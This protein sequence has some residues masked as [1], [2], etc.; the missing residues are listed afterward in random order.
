MIRALLTGTLTRYWRSLLS[1]LLITVFLSLA[2]FSFLSIERLAEG[3]L[4]SATSQELGKTK[5]Q[6]SDDEQLAGELLK[7]IEKQKEFSTFELVTKREAFA[8]STHQASSVVINSFS[9]HTE[10]K[11]P[12]TTGEYPQN[13]DEILISNELAETLNVDIGQSL[14][15]LINHDSSQY[16]IGKVVGVFKKDFLTLEPRALEIYSTN[17]DFILGKNWLSTPLQDTDKINLISSEKAHSAA[18][19]TAAVTKISA[20]TTLSRA[21]VQA[22]IRNTLSEQYRYYIYTARWLVAA[23]TL[24]AIAVL[25]ISFWRYTDLRQ[26]DFIRLR[27]LG[28]SRR[29][30]ITIQALEFFTIVFF[31]ALITNFMIR[32]ILLGIREDSQLLSAL[33]FTIKENYFTW[34]GFLISILIAIIIGILCTIPALYRT[35]KKLELPINKKNTATN[36]QWYSLSFVTFFLTLFLG[37]ITLFALITST[38][39][40]YWTAT[41]EDNPQNF[42]PIAIIIGIISLGFFITALIKKIFVTENIRILPWKNKISRSIISKA[43]AVQLTFGSLI[44]FLT[45]ATITALWTT[46]NYSQFVYETYNQHSQP[47]DFAIYAAPNS[48]INQQSLTSIYDEPNV[49]RILQ[50]K[51]IEATLKEENSTSTDTQLIH[52]ASPRNAI[53]YFAEINDK[54]KSISNNT[55]IINPS[56]S[57]LK[58]TNEKAKFRVI[59][60]EYNLNIALKEVESTN[61]FWTVLI[62]D[63]DSLNG[64]KSTQEIVWT[65]IDTENSN[66]AQTITSVIDNFSSNQSLHLQP[67]TTISEAEIHNVD[68]ELLATLTLYVT[69]ALTIVVITLR[70]AEVQRLKTQSQATLIRLGYSS[71]KIK[72]RYIQQATTRIFFNSLGGATTGATAA[73]YISSVFLDQFPFT[74]LANFPIQK[75]VIL[76]AATTFSSW[77]ALHL[78]KRIQARINYI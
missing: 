14:T 18:E 23:P 2:I 33:P 38:Q 17:L 9:P 63:T 59:A 60:P 31:T 41:F 47:F 24:I 27:I 48:H 77:I 72:N 57:T 61:Y 70:L 75:I 55:L 3:N 16:L 56:I 5:F 71:E 43:T 15:V 35:A 12:L 10:V 49:N 73:Y 19:L 54:E 4:Y 26:S 69:L 32:A 62:T 46:T 28:F 39:G 53:N 67:R 25:A 76:I 11:I 6:I 66:L 58:L 36:A 29:K 65:L 52:L 51:A 42:A 22:Q 1:P 50:L 7:K 20:K 34:T 8:I 44:L 45:T 40:L 37:A 68:L 21:Q 64:I 13:I 78:I 74:L 30:I